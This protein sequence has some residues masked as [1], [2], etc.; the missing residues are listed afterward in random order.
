MFRATWF[1]SDD[2]QRA[3][4]LAPMSLCS[5]HHCNRGM[6]YQVIGKNNYMLPI[7]YLKTCKCYQND[8][9]P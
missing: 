6:L 1:L 8:H 4:A 7:N 3:S 2:N 5:I 9:C